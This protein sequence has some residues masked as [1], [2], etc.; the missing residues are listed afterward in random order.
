MAFVTAHTGHIMTPCF[1]FE[2]SVI[3]HIIMCKHFGQ[4]ACPLINL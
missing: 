2:N 4:Y 3:N 1:V